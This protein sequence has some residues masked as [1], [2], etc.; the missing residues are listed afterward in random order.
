MW[1]QIKGLDINVLFGNLGDV[2]KVTEDLLAK[3]E[4]DQMEIGKDQVWL[5]LQAGVREWLLYYLSTFWYYR[6]VFIVN[7]LFHT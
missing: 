2:V 3:L 4:T 5:D 7:L 6:S 1:L